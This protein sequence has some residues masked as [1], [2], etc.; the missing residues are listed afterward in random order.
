MFTGTRT[1]VQSS[2]P[3]PV[4]PKGCVGRVRARQFRKRYQTTQP[5]GGGLFPNVRVNSIAMGISETIV[6]V[7]EQSIDSYGGKIFMRQ[8]FETYQY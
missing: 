4:L 6:I 7:T 8:D 5:G 2:P 3:P 1:F